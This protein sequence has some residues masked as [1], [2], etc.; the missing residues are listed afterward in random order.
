MTAWCGWTPQ[1][2]PFVASG[3]SS[4]GRA[5]AASGTA[6]RC[7]A[8]SAQ[9]SRP[10]L[11]RSQRAAASAASS[12]AQ[13]PE[14][15]QQRQR[16]RASPPPAPPP[17]SW[18][19]QQPGQPAAGQTSHTQEL[20][21]SSAAPITSFGFARGFSDKYELAEQL[22]SGTFGI[23]HV[24]VNRETGERWVGGWVLCGWVVWCGMLLFA[25]YVGCSAIACSPG[26]CV[27]ARF[28]QLP[29]CPPTCSA[30]PPARL[31]GRPPAAGLL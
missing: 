24:A 16:Q 20:Y 26:V 17:P 22:G 3:C 4:S 5:A 14:A 2:Q 31:P 27:L 25:A 21:S 29:P 28:A 30:P 10:R 9:G 19:T 18:Q 13:P 15:Q 23:V 8:P 1:Q 6:G 11:Q 12:A 7:W